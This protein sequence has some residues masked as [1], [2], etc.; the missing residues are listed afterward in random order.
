MKRTRLLLF[1]GL[2][3]LLAAGIA[4]GQ[5]GTDIRADYHIWSHVKTMV[6]EEGHPLFGPFGGIHHIYANKRALSGYRKQKFP[7]GAILVF[8]LY[9]AKRE[10]NAI[11]EGPKKL[12]AYM[13]K[14]SARFMET[15]G[16]GFSAFKA[17]SSENFVKDPKK[18]CFDCHA[19]RKDNDYVFSSPVK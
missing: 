9:E 8:E 18:E 12:T 14:N 13:K 10:N 1:I 3:L 19:T 16:W 4:F 5:R 11:T 6:I 15:G 17:G 2:M 7:D